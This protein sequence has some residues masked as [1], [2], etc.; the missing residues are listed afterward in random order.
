MNARYKYHARQRM[1]DCSP[2]IYIATLIA[3]LLPS[4][5]QMAFARILFGNSIGVYALTQAVLEDRM[6]AYLDLLTGPQLAYF[7]FVSFM[8]SIITALLKYGYAFYCLKASR[9]EEV[10][11]SDLFYGFAWRPLR[12]I[13]AEFFIQLRVALLTFLFVIP[14]I[15][16]A[17]S[18]SQT[19]LVLIDN[20]D[21]PAWQA[22]NCSRDLMRGRR[23]DFFC[24]NLSFLG[25]QILSGLTYGISGVYSDPYQ[26][27]AQCG[28]YDSLTGAAPEEW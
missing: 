14:G 15:L 12:V 9:G 25:W 11:L 20:P 2:G 16:A 19:Y 28:F 7:G 26:K 18:Y 4:L 3:A 24:L 17:F 21:M 13:L 10:T 27:L 1:A 23:W 6:D 5:L 8:L 22:I